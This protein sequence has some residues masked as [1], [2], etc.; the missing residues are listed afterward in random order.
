MS[1]QKGT[2]GLSSNIE[3]SM[4][5]PLDAREVVNTLEDLTDSASFPYYYEG[6]T[7]YVKSEQKTY[8]LI[9]DP[10]DID[11]WTAGGSGEQG[12]KGDKGDKGD[13][14]EQGPQGEQGPKGDK[15]ED[16]AQGPKGEDGEPGPKGDTGVQGP[17]GDK[18]DPGEQ[19]PKGDKGEQGPKGDTG[20]VGPQGPKGD[21]GDTGPQGPK[22]DK[23]DPGT[24]SQVSVTPILQTGTKIAEIDIDG[25]TSEL[26]APEG[27]NSGHIIK[28]DG[29]DMTARSGLNFTDFDLTDDSTNDEIDVKPHELT[30]AEVNEILSNLP[31]PSSSTAPI[32]NPY[33]DRWLR[34]DST[35]HKGLIIKANTTIRQANSVCTTFYSDTQIDLTEYITENGKDYYLYMDNN[36]EFSAYTEYQTDVTKVQIGRFH[37]LCVGVGSNV[38]MIVSTEQTATGGNY[39]IKPYNQDKDEDFYNLYNKQITSISTGSPYNVATLEHPLNGYV[40][41]DILPESVM[42]LN[43]YADTLIEDGMVYDKT[44]SRF[45]DI[46][47]QSG[48]G[49]STRSKYNA[50]HTV[51]RQQINHQADMLAVGKRLLTDYEFTSM[52]I[53]SNEATN[54][55]GSADVTTVGGHLDTNDRRMISAIGAEDACGLIWQWLGE[56]SGCT[57]DNWRIR[58]GRGSFGQEYRD[59][60]ALIAGGCWDYGVHCGSR[61]R[62]AYNVR[63]SVVANLGGRGS[64]RVATR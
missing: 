3:P 39:L 16:G 64:S 59:C 30:T 7:V 1:R 51:S 44:T 2:L 18:G 55:K 38:T 10:S 63:S 29:T 37:T 58:D 11:N 28:N 52:A 6:I 34:F 40:A 56:Y 31:A 8:T 49:Q 54:I 47:L 43:W 5:A 9:G 12:P 35:N 14:G 33:C 36:G 20:E 42:C 57:T 22:G 50:V 26:Y 46:Y 53:G 4:N 15:G 23:G 24:G 61:S 21:K 17:K 62:S 27:G 45:I 60:I 41:G 19:G 32:G 13:P 25:D 48:T